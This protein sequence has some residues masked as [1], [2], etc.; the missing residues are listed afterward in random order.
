MVTYSFGVAR[1]PKKEVTQDTVEK[2]LD[3]CGRSLEQGE[4][5]TLVKASPK[6][7]KRL[8]LCG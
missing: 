5:G 8:A 2:I 6:P 7:R 3:R 4:C 1:A